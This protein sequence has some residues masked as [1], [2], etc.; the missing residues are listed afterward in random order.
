MLNTASV[1]PGP[2]KPTLEAPVL[3]V[4]CLALLAGYVDAV[5]YLSLHAFAANMTG[6]V[7]F[8]GLALA[9]LR[10]AAAAMH[11]TTVLA[12]LGGMIASRGL[13]R[14][15]RGP[16]PS[17]AV[18]ALFPLAFAMGMQNAAVTR[19]GGVGLNTPFITGDL[20]RLGE[21]LADPHPSREKSGAAAKLLPLAVLLAY[22]LGA[23]GG[24][25]AQR[26]FGQ[27]LLLPALG[28]LIVSAWFTLLTNKARTFNYTAGD[29]GFVPR[30]LGH[31]IENI[32]ETT[33]RVFNVFNT[34]KYKDVSLN[35]W[36][37][38]TPPDLVRGHFNVDESVIKA[39]K[40]ERCSVVR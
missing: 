29:V 6:M 23:A 27:P 30:T 25:V 32:G 40:R 8:L 28:A 18:A 5:G 36:L 19:F 9:N 37:A 39:L 2:G 14:L 13:L 10:P 35:N 12:F 7:I 4:P 20:E 31:Y 15:G 11:A 21:A 38:L 34:P 22:A 16:A 24:A 3:A 26:T 33:V 17:L 1:P